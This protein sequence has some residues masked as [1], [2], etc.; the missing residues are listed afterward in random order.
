MFIQCNQFIYQKCFSIAVKS[1]QT[2]PLKKQT[3][4]F[5][6]LIPTFMSEYDSTILPKMAFSVKKKKKFTKDFGVGNFKNW[7]FVFV[8]L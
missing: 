2:S 1:K 8:S 3:N 4:M 5:L 6:V 7:K